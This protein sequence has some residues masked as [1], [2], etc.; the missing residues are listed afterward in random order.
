MFTTGSDILVR[1]HDESANGATLPA[2]VVEIGEDD[3]FCAAFATDPPG[4]VDTP[5][6]ILFHDDRRRF[7]RVSAMLVEAD[8][9]YEGSPMCRIQACPPPESAEKRQSF[10]VT[11]AGLNLIAD[12]GPAHKC[13]VHDVGLGGFAAVTAT[14]LDVD[15]VFPVKL[16]YGDKHCEG[17]VRVCNV[18]ETGAAAKRYGLQALKSDTN[19]QK[20]LQTIAISVQRVQLKRRQGFASDRE[21]LAAAAKQASETDGAVETQEEYDSGKCLRLVVPIHQMVGRRLPVSL[22]NENGEV[23]VEAGAVLTADELQK[24]STGE[25]FLSEEWLEQPGEEVEGDEPTAEAAEESDSGDASEKKRPAKS[26]SSRGKDRR[27]FPRVPWVTDAYVNVLDP[28]D[29]R[30]IQVVTCDLSRGGFSFFAN[31]YI[32]DG[33]E[34]M[35]EVP[36]GREIQRL[37]V[38]VVCCDVIDAPTHRVGVQF[39]QGRPERCELRSHA[40]S[41]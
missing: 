10:R 33:A 15:A 29:Q 31:C 30:Q 26:S 1:F 39:V 6:E 4:A 41:A 11:V 5:V 38:R 8:L 14:K 32:Y 22:M 7:M 36:V 12:I 19:L 37:R 3:T 2:R 13:M 25:V 23:I 16:R 28:N 27:T 9:D 35:V 20:W 24:I 40:V 18:I 34:L 17:R 21:S